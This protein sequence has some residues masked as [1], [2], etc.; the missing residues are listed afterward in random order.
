[1]AAQRCARHGPQT[2]SEAG[3][4]ADAMILETV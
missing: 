4:P 2:V 1:M 3:G